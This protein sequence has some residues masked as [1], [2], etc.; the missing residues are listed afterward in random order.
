MRAAVY[1][2]VPSPALGSQETLCSLGFLGW[3][4]PS[5][6]TLRGWFCTS[7]MEGWTK[8]EVG[9]L[10]RLRPLGGKVPEGGLGLP[11]S[12]SPTP[13]SPLN[14]VSHLPPPPPPNAAP[15]LLPLLLLILRKL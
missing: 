7:L 10:P 9:P 1:L 14:S 15:Q 4:T 12:S 6:G 11:P 13:P 2:P 5:A 3:E 8:L